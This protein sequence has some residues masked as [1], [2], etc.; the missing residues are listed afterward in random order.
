MILRQYRLSGQTVT[1]A[2]FKRDFLNYASRDNFIA[3]ADAFLEDQKISGLM[4][5]QT[6]KNK[7]NR[8]KHFSEFANKQVLFA[9]LTPQLI[10]QFDLY[11]RKKSGL[12]KHNSIQSIHVGIKTFIKV[13]IA[14]GV[15]VDNPYDKFKIKPYQPGNRISLDKL[16]LSRLKILYS[17]KE[18]PELE[19]ETLRKFLF[20]CYTGIRIS[21]SARLRYENIDD[22]FLKMETFKTRRFGKNVNI[23]LPDFAKQLLGDGNWGLIFK[24]IADQTVNKALKEIAIKA[25]INKRLTFHVSRDTFAT[26]FI[27]LGGDVASLKELLA[28]TKTETAMIYVKMSEKRKETLMKNF[29]KI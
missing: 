14:E 4:S 18:L 25:E 10:S 26:F 7:K 1:H 17:K 20:S 8:L 12:K 28:I 27:E 29:N 22:G 11:L 23:A 9:E 5:E 13:A 6:Y 2:Q 3:W 19:Q 24:T 21:D 15:N 16:E